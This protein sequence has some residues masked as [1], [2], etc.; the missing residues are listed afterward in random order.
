MQYRQA[1]LR[2]LPRLPRVA[3]PVYQVR[4]NRRQSADA[5]PQQPFVDRVLYWSS[6]LVHCFVIVFSD[7]RMVKN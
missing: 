5:E 1:W 4:L 3:L 6:W 2:L 7:L